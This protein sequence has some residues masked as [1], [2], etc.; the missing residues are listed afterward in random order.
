ML[1]EASPLFSG[2]V[3]IAAQIA[4]HPLGDLNPRLYALGAVGD[5][6]GIVDI[7]SGDNTFTRLA[8]GKPVFTVPGYAAGP[9]YDMASGLGTIDAQRFTHALANG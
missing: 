4:G 3:A 5:R 2:I 9:G 1:S 7:T 8:N 6:A